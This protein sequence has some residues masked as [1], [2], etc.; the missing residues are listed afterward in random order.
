MPRRRPRWYLRYLVFFGSSISSCSPETDH[1]TGRASSGPRPVSS[2]WSCPAPRRRHPGRPASRAGPPAARDPRPKRR[3]HRSAAA[4]RSSSGRGLRRPPPRRP[5]PPP[6]PDPL[7]VGARSAPAFAGRAQ[8]LG[9]ATS[10]AGLVLI[11]QAP[12]ASAFDRLIALRHDLA[13]VDP[14][15][16]ADPT[17]G[18]LRL[19]EAVV[20]V[21]SDRVQRHA[22]LGVGLGTAHLGA[23]ESSGAGDLH[24]V[25][26]GADR[27][28]E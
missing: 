17:E 25:G 23:A 8:T 15:L 7:A 3:F 4:R 2:A 27:R 18:R 22:T 20:D 19:D 24:P 14:D 26:A 11:P 6:A 12:I 5:P 1:P 16:H 10:P 21:R 9:A 28:C 13:L